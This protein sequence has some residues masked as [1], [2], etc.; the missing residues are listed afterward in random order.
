DQTYPVCPE[1]VAVLEPLATSHSLIVWSALPVARVL[2][3]GLKATE[4]SQS[5]C[6]V[7][8]AVRWPVATSHNLRAVPPPEASVLP[9]GL[10][11]RKSTKPLR[12]R[13]RVFWPPGTLQ[14]VTLF[15]TLP[16]A[17][18]LPS[19]LNARGPM[20]ELLLRK[21]AVF[22]KLATSHSWTTPPVM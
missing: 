12:L 11:D 4:L 16:V 17:T 6:P 3:S 20:A 5:V 10:K 1:N 21:V 22:W 14:N 7:R 9:S 18:D 8:V 15:S 13:V 19:G 2:P